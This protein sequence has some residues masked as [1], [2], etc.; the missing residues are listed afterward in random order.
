MAA[1]E[2]CWG[3]K[4]EPASVYHPLCP[5]HKCCPSCYVAYYRTVDV[6]VN[7]RISFFAPDAIV[8]SKKCCP[9][10]RKYATDPVTQ[11]FVQN[12]PVYFFPEVDGD[13]LRSQARVVRAAQHRLG[14]LFT[15]E[16]MKQQAELVKQVAG[17]LSSLETLSESQL[18][19]V[20]LVLAELCSKN[21]I[22]IPSANPVLPEDNERAETNQYELTTK[23]Y[24]SLPGGGGH[25]QYTVQ[26][27][28]FTGCAATS[29]TSA[30]WVEHFKERHTR[31]FVC[32]LD[33]CR[34]VFEAHDAQSLSL[35]VQV[36][37][38]G[39]NCTGDIQNITVPTVSPPTM[40]RD[41]LTAAFR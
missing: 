36:H 41:L 7:G 9:I 22:Q 18:K 23:Y 19:T 28:P 38:A 33:G 11:A 14:G 21:M 5:D 3:C 1:L 39:A 12:P 31:S 6:K 34:H 10:C 40:L 15:Q 13:S 26:K 24:Y 2:L 4:E 16:V 37:L 29:L 27:C 20:C 8:L 25:N 17:H 30:E 35:A 32:P